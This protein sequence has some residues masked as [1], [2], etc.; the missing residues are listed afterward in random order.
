[1]NLVLNV[2]SNLHSVKGS[3]EGEQKIHA[4]I[5]EAMDSIKAQAVINAKR[6]QKGQKPLPYN[7]VVKDEYGKD[8]VSINEVKTLAEIRQAYQKKQDELDYDKKEKNLLKA[9]DEIGN[10][11]KSEYLFK[12]DLNKTLNS[13]LFVTDAKLTPGLEKILD[14]FGDEKGLVNSINFKEDISTKCI[15]DLIDMPDP[16]TGK[17]PKSFEQLMSNIVSI[18]RIFE[19]NPNRD[20]YLE[21]VRSYINIRYK[22]IIPEEYKFCFEN[23]A[24]LQRL[25]GRIEKEKEKNSKVEN[26]EF[27][28][29]EKNFKKYFQSFSTLEQFKNKPRELAKYLYERVPENS[30][31]N[32]AKWMESVG[33]KDEVSIVKVLTKWSNEAEKSKDVKKHQVK[34]KNSPSEISR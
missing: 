1:M 3:A 22:K 30:R 31:K 18:N 8:L 26:L 9:M 7:T 13:A 21:T 11:S 17:P 2:N 4:A 10:S 29:S 16:K 20:K 23:K 19:N 15:R 28:V 24:E 5:A 33:M 34:E 6:V 27:E 32:F 14:Y 25:I 12:E